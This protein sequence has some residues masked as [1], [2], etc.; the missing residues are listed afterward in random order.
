MKNLNNK[1]KV[2]WDAEKFSADPLFKICP[3]DLTSE[4]L[5]E[6]R[7]EIFFQYP[8]VVVIYFSIA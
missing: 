7:T 5:L 2:T 1:K 6:S 8:L 3:N 4:F